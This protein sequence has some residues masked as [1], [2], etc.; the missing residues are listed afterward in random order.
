[1]P[2]MISIPAATSSGPRVSG[3]RG[4]IR[5]ASAPDRAESSSM[6]RVTGSAAAPAA[7][8]RVAEYDLEHDH[9]QEEDAAERRVDDEGDRVGGR[10]LA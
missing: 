7:I 9:E 3:S 6:I 4:P 10:E 1:M 8:G 5:W 2:L